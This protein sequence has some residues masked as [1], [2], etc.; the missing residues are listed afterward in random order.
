MAL[1]IDGFAVFRSIGSHPGAFSSIGK[2]VGKL[3][4]SLIVKQ[5]RAKT[6]DLNSLRDICTALGV[7]TFNLILDGLT[8]DQI[9]S[10][11]TRID[12]HHPEVRVAAP[13]WRLQRIRALVH[14]AAEP[15]A[16]T[17]VVRKSAKVNK[18]SARPPSAPERLAYM[19]AGATRRR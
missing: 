18:V 19:S 13:E 14:G 5:M 10:L 17:K 1:E 16:K 11:V 7:E 8:D 6:S 3:A 15:F 12:K 9:R 2:E 4:S